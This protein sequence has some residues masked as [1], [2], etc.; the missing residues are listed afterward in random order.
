M[1]IIGDEIL[2][3][4]GVTVFDK[5]VAEVV[6]I[7]RQCPTEFLA[8]VRPITSVHKALKTDF[9]KTNYSSVVHNKTPIGSEETNGDRF[10]ESIEIDGNSC[11]N[12]SYEYATVKPLAARNIVGR[13]EVNECIN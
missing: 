12:G 10:Y 11:N 8:T 3:I 6:E 9:R 1:S 4:H 5:S 13:L 7:I 2:D